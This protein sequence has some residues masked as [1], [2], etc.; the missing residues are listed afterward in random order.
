M[1]KRYHCLFKNCDCVKFQLF[2]EKRCIFCKHG[3]VWHS[4]IER[5][6]KTFKSQ[7]E[8]CRTFAR[9][10][11]YVNYINSIP[12]IFTPIPIVNA[13]PINE[14]LNYCITVEALPV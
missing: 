12:T 4:L 13:R 14:E 7:F 6:L 8:S 5:P 11:I 9:K 3:E 10:P 1:K 2:C